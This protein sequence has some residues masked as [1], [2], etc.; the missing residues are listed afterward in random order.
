[1]TNL[2][3]E[4]EE[5]LKTGQQ[6]SRRKTTEVMVWLISNKD[7]QWSSE[8]PNSLHV[9]FGLKDYRFSAEN[10][11]SATNYIL[12]KCTEHGIQIPLLAFVGQWYTLLVRNDDRNPLTKLQLQKDVW[13]EVTKM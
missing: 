13:A 6:L 9:A 12:E 8:L 5:C 4:A 2:L 10:L 7:R 1:M 11:R 3:N